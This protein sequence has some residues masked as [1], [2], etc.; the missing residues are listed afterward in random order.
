M[1]GGIFMD[2]STPE[3]NARQAI[4]AE[5]PLRAGGFRRRQEEIS[6]ELQPFMWPDNPIPRREDV[7]IL[8]AAINRMALEVQ[9]PPRKELWKGKGVN[10][11]NS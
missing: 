8:T 10:T 5:Y 7:F 6:G 1:P 11:V 2:I 3:S 9:P 4:K